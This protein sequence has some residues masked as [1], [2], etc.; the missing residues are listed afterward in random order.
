MKGEEC[1]ILECDALWF[2]EGPQKTEFF[3]VT[4]ME[5]SYLTSTKGVIFWDV[6]PCSPLGVYEHSGRK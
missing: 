3:T 6:T 4:A 5:T 1:R 2:L